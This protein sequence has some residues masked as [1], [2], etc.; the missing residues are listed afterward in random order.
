M[1]T[2]SQDKTSPIGKILF[3]I[4]VFYVCAVVGVYLANGTSLVF[5]IFTSEPLMSG[6]T[7]AVLSLAAVIFGFIIFQKRKFTSQPLMGLGII[8]ALAVTYGMAAY[9]GP[10]ASS[11]IPGVNEVQNEAAQTISMAQDAIWKLI[12]FVIALLC[13]IPAIRMIDPDAI[14]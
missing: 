2:N 7:S 12:P 11:I 1:T 5:G 9:I 6:I 8:L 3:F 10:G 4:S 13:T 14:K